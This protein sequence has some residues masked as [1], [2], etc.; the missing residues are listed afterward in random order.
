MTNPYYDY[1]PRGNSGQPFAEVY[2]ARNG[3]N[4]FYCISDKLASE[5]CELL[6][7]VSP[8]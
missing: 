6:N 8:A 2:E 4:L 7:G 3:E 1:E 5:L